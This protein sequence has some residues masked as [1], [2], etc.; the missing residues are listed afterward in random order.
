METEEFAL[1][2]LNDLTNEL[3]RLLRQKEIV[4]ERCEFQKARAIDCHIKKMRQEIQE[5]KAMSDNLQINL[6]FE[7]KKE[8]VCLAATQSLKTIT[9]LFLTKKDEY[10]QKLISIHERQNER[11]MLQSEEYA[12]ELELAASRENPETKHLL[13]QA[14]YHARNCQYDE[15][16]DCFQR[17][18]TIRNDT[19]NRRQEEV[20]TKYERAKKLLDK[21]YDHEI[22]ILNEIYTAHFAEELNKFNQYI[23]RSKRFLSKQAARLNYQMKPEDTSFLDEYIKSAQAEASCDIAFASSITNDTNSVDANLDSTLKSTKPKTPK[24]KTPKK[25]VTKTPV[26]RKCSLLDL[27]FNNSIRRSRMTTPRK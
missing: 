9:D 17:S 20:H 8:Q 4:I 22:K 14:Q 18:N 19:S 6:E 16:D 26:S 1:N 25:N 2:P 27:P 13:K 15:A 11:V 21:Q 5:S 7:M 10:Q 12:K 24:Q 3:D 23:E